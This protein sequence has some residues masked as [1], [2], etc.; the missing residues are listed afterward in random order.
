LAVGVS[1]DKIITATF[2]EAMNPLTIT[3]ESFTLELAAKG[4]TLVTGTVRI[5]E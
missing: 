2:N 4:V 3:Q 5:P 1:L